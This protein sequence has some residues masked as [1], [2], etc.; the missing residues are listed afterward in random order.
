MSWQ[1][2]IVLDEVTEVDVLL[3][4]MP[5][6]AQTTPERK[7]ASK[8]LWCDWDA[9]WSPEPSLTL[10]TT[11]LGSPLEKLIDDIPTVELH[12][13]DLACV[14]IFGLQDNET[15][16][17]SLAELGYLPT[18]RSAYPGIGFARPA[19]SLAN[20]S[21]VILDARNW[22]SWDDFYADFFAAVGAPEWHGRNFNALIDS[23]GTG[24][25]NKIEVPYRIVIRNVSANSEISKMVV[26]D[27]SHLILRL[28]GEGCPVSLTVDD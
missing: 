25:I 24:R 4:M 22:H 13:S 19:E 12:Y 26:A 11:P 28:Q 17:R 1:V 7:A 20:L 23:I 5:V 6:W 3:G 27:F 2:A 8:Q 16:R 14:R 21:E 9:L 18:T 10:F 15:L